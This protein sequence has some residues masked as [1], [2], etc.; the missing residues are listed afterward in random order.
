MGGVRGQ[1]LIGIIGKNRL[2]MIRMNQDILIVTSV[3]GAE[4]GKK[5]TRYEKK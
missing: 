1:R 2:V 4:P 5:C 3:K